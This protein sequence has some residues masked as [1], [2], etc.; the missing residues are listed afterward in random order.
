LGNKEAGESTSTTG[1]TLVI[2]FVPPAGAGIDKPTWWREP[3]EGPVSSGCLNC[4]SRPYVHPLEVKLGVGFG[5]CWVSRDDV[6]VW[7]EEDRDE[8]CPTLGQFEDM[9]AEDPDH[10]W[11][12][13]YDAP[14]WNGTWQRHD[15]EWVCVEK[16]M[17]FA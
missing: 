1:P 17:G 13:V 6:T 8:D 12:V 14:L 16:G 4:G 9:A 7:H 11:Q 5:G 3:L 2:G 15:G 10:D